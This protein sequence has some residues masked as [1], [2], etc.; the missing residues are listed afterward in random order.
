[1]AP[2]VNYAQAEPLID[3]KAPVSYNADRGA[4]AVG[5]TQARTVIVSPMAGSKRAVLYV[6]FPA[7][8]GGR[9]LR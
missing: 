9:G 5:Q 3:N 6:A 8:S 7:L 1:L 4:Q 2:N